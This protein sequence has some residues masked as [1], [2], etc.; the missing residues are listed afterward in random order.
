MHI[1]RISNLRDV[2]AYAATTLL[3]LGLAA[4]A[5]AQTPAPFGLDERPSNTTCLPWDRPNAGASVSV[6]R[7]FDQVFGANAVNRLTVLKQAPGDSSEWIFATEAGLIGRFDNT[8]GVS[9]WTEMMDIRGQVFVLNEGGLVG[10]AFHPDYPSDPRIFLNY[11]TAPTGGESA[12]I[13][14]SS[15][16]TTHGGATFDP[17]TEVILIRQSRGRFHQ[18]GVLEF[19]ADGML[20]ISIGDGAD[21]RDPLGWAQN[22]NDFRGSVLRIDVD[23]GVPYSIP[24]DNPFASSGGSPLPEI[25]AYGFRS[26]YRGHLDQET[27][28]LWIADVGYNQWEEV[29]SV[30]TSEAVRPDLRERGTAT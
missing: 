6:Q 12:D 8:P 17:S 2:A 25:W 20:L 18:G 15:I 9:D 22:L 3:L 16:E 24:P 29:A 27:Q 26:P 28:Q 14:I 11:S 10:L 4:S 1:V 30:W 13:I 7:V 23:S 19:D 5:G 21:Q